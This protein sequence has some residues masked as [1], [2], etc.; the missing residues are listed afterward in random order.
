M[1]SQWIQ[2]IKFLPITVCPVSGQLTFYLQPV[3]P[4]RHPS[5]RV[6]TATTAA[7]V[8]VRTGAEEARLQRGCQQLNESVAVTADAVYL[9]ATTGAT[10]VDEDVSGAT[11]NGDA[12]A[13]RVLRGVGWGERNR[14]SLGGGV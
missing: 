3:Q 7:A 13:N 5:R 14:G 10:N 1:R 6:A 8:V 9:D 12:S 11:A 4:G 2:V